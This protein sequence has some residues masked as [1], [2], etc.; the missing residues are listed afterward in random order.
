MNMKDVMKGI[1]ALVLFVMLIAGLD[2]TG[3][4]W[5]SFMSPKKEEMRRNVW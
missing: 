1:G 2:Y 5:E 3:F 4:I